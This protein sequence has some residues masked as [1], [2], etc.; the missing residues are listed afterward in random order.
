MTGPEQLWPDR[1]SPQ[2]GGFRVDGRWD[3]IQRGGVWFG[4]DGAQPFLV[5]DG[6]E[7]TDTADEKIRELIG[8]PQ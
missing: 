7:P 5:L 1:V 4:Y 8:D 6:R 2:P 3:V